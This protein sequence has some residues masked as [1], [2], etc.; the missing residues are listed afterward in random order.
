MVVVYCIE[1]NDVNKHEI[2]SKCETKRSNKYFFRN[3][4]ENDW[5]AF[6]FHVFFRSSYTE[7]SQSP[8]ILQETVDFEER[9]ALEKAITRDLLVLGC[10]YWVTYIPKLTVDI[11]RGYTYWWLFYQTNGV[12]FFCQSVFLIMLIQPYV[13]VFSRTFAEFFLRSGIRRLLVTTVGTYCEHPVNEYSI[14]QYL[15]QQ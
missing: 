7:N 1:Y 15:D 14:H 10:F 4:Q 5:K 8:V 12:S 9:R 13:F 3:M 2:C 11:I 6:H